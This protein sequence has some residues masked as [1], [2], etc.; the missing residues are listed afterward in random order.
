[1]IEEKTALQI[2]SNII[3]KFYDDAI[4]P[5]AQELG[6]VM[7]RIAHSLRLIGLIGLVG[8]GAVITEK[9]LK[10]KMEKFLYDSFSKTPNEKRVLPDPTIICPLLENV[11]NSFNKEDIVKLYSNLLSAA[12]NKDTT[13]KVHPAF[14]NI[15]T[16][17]TP[18]DAE[19]F[20]KL[21][22][23]FYLTVCRIYNNELKDTYILSQNIYLDKNYS[24]VNT[25]VSISIN[26]LERLG[27]IQK[28]AKSPYIFEINK[29]EPVENC[30]KQ[31]K[32]YENKCLKY[33]EKNIN[34]FTQ[35]AYISELGIA[36]KNIC[37]ENK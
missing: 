1:M 9:I 25:N 17:L 3:A 2:V 32:Y 18:L 13:E 21:D 10:E 15:I 27:L 11:A 19:V 8:D 16:Q 26:N 33:G 24:E 20:S 12:T 7:G 35:K 4:H 22:E 23:R 6:Y 37:F 29:N 28:E 5:P 31:T 36:F 30:F 14:I 34:I